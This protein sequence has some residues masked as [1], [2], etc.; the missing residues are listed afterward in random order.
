[1]APPRPSSEGYSAI[2]DVKNVHEYITEDQPWNSRTSEAT[3]TGAVTKDP[4]TYNLSFAFSLM[5]GT[6][7]FSMFLWGAWIATFYSMALANR[8]WDSFNIISPLWDGNSLIAA[9][10][11]SVHFMGAAFMSLA[12]AFQ[13]IKFIRKHYAILHRWV[14]RLY[15][16]AS[17]FV[18]CGGL[19]F[20]VT[21]GSSGGRESDIAFGVYGLCFLC[22]CFPCYYSA[23]VAKD[24]SAHKLWAWRLYSLAL[25]AWIYR[26]EY[27]FWLLGFGKSRSVLLLHA[28][29]YMLVEFLE[30]ILSKFRI[31]HRSS[32]TNVVTR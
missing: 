17:F 31:Q 25:S 28:N 4:D 3:P 32:W 14:G 11:I 10:A 19:T 5:S 24:F 7:W 12:G 27:V 21:K 1:M 16:V 13:L 22:C 6:V 30:T 26:V 8:N 23:A 9:I 2:P 29:C 20:I 18:S 15:I